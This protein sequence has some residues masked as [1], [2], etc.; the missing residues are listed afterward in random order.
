[1]IG[2]YTLTMLCEKY[3]VDTNKVVNKNNNILEYGEY[4][5]I[6]YTLNYL[7]N[8]LGINPKNIEKCPS[9]LYRNV[10]QIKENISFIKFENIS[11]SNIETCLHVFSTDSNELQNTYNYV[12]KNY[13]ILAIEKVTSI[14]SVHVNIILA[15]E[16]LDI[17]FVNRIGNLSVAVGVEWGSTNIEEIQ[18]IIQSPEFK[19]HPE[20]FT[21]QT[22]AHAKLEEIQKIIQSPEFKEHPEM[23]TS[24]TLAH[25]KLEE[26]QKIIQGPEFKEHPEL[27]TSTTLAH[28]KLEEIQKII[29]SPEFK[30][31]PELF[32][33]QTL[34]HA[35]LE[36]IQILLKMDIWKEPKYT[37]LLTSSI[38]AKSKQMI[39]K[40]PILLEIA[41][42]YQIEG[43][44]NTSFLL[45]SPSQNYALIKY[46]EE[47]NL[48]L[49]ENNK[50][51]RIFGKQP[52]F[53]KKKY[54]IDLKNL[55]MIY[56]FDE[57]V[58]SERKTRK[59]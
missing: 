19:E 17:K 26:I 46:L 39:T 16:S 28:A 44:I 20:M 10:E 50:L 45:F 36:E 21:S 2:T 41:N 35:K 24:T 7:I 42:F 5:K 14:L 6:D 13:G 1:M 29:Q 43:Y 47:N 51:N 56:P 37:N 11:F 9:I 40:I 33:S 55:M 53:L 8:E 48:P 4:N 27:F 23:F 12:L 57:Q 31:H 38:V 30:E 34:A 52:G 54:N 32:T 59:I 3:G 49:V 58:L 15:V 18:K 22:L 25:A